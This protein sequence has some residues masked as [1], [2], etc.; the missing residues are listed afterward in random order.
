MRRIIRIGTFGLI[1]TIALLTIPIA[2]AQTS[3]DP[4]PAPIPIQ[5]LS[6][7]KAFISNGESTGEPAFGVRD[8]SY[9]Q[10]YASMKSWG[11]YELV[12]APADADLVFEIHFG[13]PL[14]LAILD[15]KT[16]IVLWSLIERVEPWSRASTGR[17]NYDQAMAALVDDVKRLTTPPGTATDAAAPNK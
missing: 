3:S 1:S 2:G 9:N 10:F 6:C 17:K 11:K 14:V 15:P 16:H 12:S 8:L 4:P 7:K 5:I 13:P